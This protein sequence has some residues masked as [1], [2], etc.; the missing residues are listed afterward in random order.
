MNVT[1]V[2][3]PVGLRIVNPGY[4]PPYVHMF[5]HGPSKSCTHASSMP[6]ETCAFTFTGGKT[7]GCEKTARVGAVLLTTVVAV[8]VFG[9]AAKRTPM[10]AMVAASK[11]VNKTL[12]IKPVSGHSS[13]VAGIRVSGLEWAAV[14]ASEWIS[15]TDWPSESK[16]RSL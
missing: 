6:M 8:M 2:L 16:S 11:I 4:V 12:V 13:P 5:V 14:L 15:A 10:P 1:S 3:C 7:S 9:P